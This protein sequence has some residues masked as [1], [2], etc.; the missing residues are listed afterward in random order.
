MTVDA[1]LEAGDTGPTRWCVLRMAGPRTLAVRD[2]LIDAGVAAWTPTQIL[3]RRRPRSTS[4]QEI[5][6]PIA[7]TFVFAPADDADALIRLLADRVVAHPAFSMLRYERRIVFLA[8]RALSGLRDAEEEARPKVGSAKK[9]RPDGHKV[10]SDVRIGDGPYAGMTG[11]V[12][13]S[14]GRR[15]LLSFGGSLGRV[16]FE[17]DRLPMAA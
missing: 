2:W 6:V 8:D 13:S 10:G 17:T 15:T 16:T 9:R 11:C 1:T 3:K 7:S 14:D 5:T 4:F 12:E